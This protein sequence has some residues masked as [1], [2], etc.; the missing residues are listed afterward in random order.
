MVVII[1]MMMIKIVI[2]KEN[3]DIKINIIIKNYTIC[4]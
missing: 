4:Y 3:S 1:K 2:V